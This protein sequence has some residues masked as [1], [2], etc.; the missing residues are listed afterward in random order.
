[1]TSPR[2]GGGG[3]QPDQGAVGGNGRGQGAFP[4]HKVFEQFAQPFDQPGVAQG[5]A[6]EFQAALSIPVPNEP[7]DGRQQ[8]FV[9][10][11]L[12]PFPQQGVVAFGQFAAGGQ[13][14]CGGCGDGVQNGQRVE[15]ALAGFQRRQQRDDFSGLKAQVLQEK[16]FRNAPLIGD[17][18][19]EQRGLPVA[20]SG[21]LL[22]G[23]EG[24]QLAD[25]LQHIDEELFGAGYFKLAHPDDHCPS[26]GRIRAR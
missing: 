9:P 16:P 12:L 23:L 20:G 24:P 7:V 4:F 3:N 13:V 25:G 5:D 22:I 14:P 8:Y 21:A 10:L 6:D 11:Q 26:P 2:E 17:G 18:G 19:M 1:M 15:P